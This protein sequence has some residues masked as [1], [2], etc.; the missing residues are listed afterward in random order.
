MLLQYNTGLSLMY[1]FELNGSRRQLE[2][3]NSKI[4][5]GNSAPHAEHS[6][7]PSTY[8]HQYNRAK[9]PYDLECF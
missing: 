9:C 2:N 5:G 4:T 7:E 1:W 8:H 6:E 3:M